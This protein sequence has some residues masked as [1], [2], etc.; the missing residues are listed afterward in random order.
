MS[1]SASASAAAAT[2]TVCAVAQFR[3]VNVRLGGEK[4]TSVLPPAA[5]AGVTVTSP[6]G[7]ES[8]TTA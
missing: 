6:E 7:S 8:S 1:T 4:V 3:V 5:R 2:V